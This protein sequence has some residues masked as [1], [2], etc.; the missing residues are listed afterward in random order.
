MAIEV[1]DACS[2]YIRKAAA[3]YLRQHG[4]PA[5]L[6]FLPGG[7]SEKYIVFLSEISV[8]VNRMTEESNFVPDKEQLE[9]IVYDYHEL[10]KL[11]EKTPDVPKPSS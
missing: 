2:V 8:V 4:L 11:L 1:L 7:I 10:L 6:G 9:N 3:G 5:G